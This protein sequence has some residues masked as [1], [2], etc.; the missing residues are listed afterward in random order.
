MAL[1]HPNIFKKKKKKQT[2]TIRFPLLSILNEL[3]F[4]SYSYSISTL[5]MKASHRLACY[6]YMHKA[7][8]KWVICELWTNRHLKPGESLKLLPDNCHGHARN[9]TI[10]HRPFQFWTAVNSI[11]SRNRSFGIILKWDIR[12]FENLCGAWA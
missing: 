1:L 12:T 11:G 3:L 8:I 10:D 2:K 5:K 6:C 9:P 4:K 7:D